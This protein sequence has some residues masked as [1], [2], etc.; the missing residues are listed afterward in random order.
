M[1]NLRWRKRAAYVGLLLSM[2]GVTS[3]CAQT[4][5]RVE[6]AQ[7][8]PSKVLAIF[9]HGFL[10]DAV[11]TWKNET[12]QASFPIL[13]Q[14]DPAFKLDT[15]VFAFRSSAVGATLNVS[16]IAADLELRLDA[17]GVLEQYESLVI[18]GHSMG[19]LIARET[20]LSYPR[21][22]AKTKATY[23][24]G[25]PTT[26]SQVATIA[27]LFSSNPALAQLATSN[28]D[29]YLGEALRRWNRAT[30]P[31]AKPYSEAI[32]SHCAYERLPTR[33]V[34]IVPQA[35][36][37]ALCNGET[38]AIDANHMDL[39]KPA[40]REATS[41]LRLAR[42]LRAVMQQAARPTTDVEATRQ[43]QKSPDADRGGSSP[44]TGGDPAKPVI[45]TPEVIKKPE[46]AK[47]KLL[48][49]PQLHLGMDVSEVTKAIGFDPKWQF[50]TDNP[51]VRMFRIDKLNAL[52]LSGEAIFFFTNSGKLGASAFVLSASASNTTVVAHFS[53]GRVSSR[54]GGTHKDGDIDVV[55]ASYQENLLS[56]L[57]KAFASFEP[58][59]EKTSDLK[60]QL[61][62]SV[63]GGS[64]NRELK[65]Q[66]ASE[67]FTR[68]VFFNRS[69][70][71][72]KVNFWFT[73]N[74]KRYSFEETRAHTGNSTFIS[75]SI[76]NR[77]CKAEV[78]IRG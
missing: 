38:E 27:R 57:M 48:F 49:Y 18:V 8:S 41:Y 10:G 69:G 13:L 62:A 22:A 7:S 32:R 29:T 6:K 56:Q 47:D 20:L 72:A 63:L 60:P 61:E 53:E 78:W 33:G 4:P 75:N 65:I 74:K 3:I 59:T 58:K 30:T 15:F 55:C 42:A 52:G 16:E 51:P 2:L 9:V 31:T 67:R 54:N 36:A 1:T 24:F 68:Q 50:S 44:T 40:D 70:D 11:S 43:K 28:P 45:L 26:G 14:Q 39:V 5:N 76:Y 17:A 19:G 12:T 46:G 23:F 73:E 34:L 71:L 25:T 37:T 64:Q 66:D 77:S 35:S 21:I